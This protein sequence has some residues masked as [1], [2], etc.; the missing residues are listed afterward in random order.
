[1]LFSPL[2]VAILE[3]NTVHAIFLKSFH[4]TKLFSDFVDCFMK[5]THTHTNI[6]IYIVAILL[7]M[8]FNKDIHVF[9]KLGEWM[10]THND[11]KSHQ[12]YRGL[13]FTVGL[14]LID[15]FSLWLISA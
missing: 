3:I 2:T 5:Y 12:E 4:S 9:L 1:M 6:Y 8:F 10:V 11:E 14:I 13:T 15:F 7:K